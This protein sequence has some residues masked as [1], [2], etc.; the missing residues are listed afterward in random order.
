MSK[1]PYEAA[2]SVVA[3]VEDVVLFSTGGDNAYVDPWGLVIKN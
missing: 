3:F 1:A 2:T